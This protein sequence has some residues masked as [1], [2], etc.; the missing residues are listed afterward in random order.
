MQQFREPTSPS[1][2]TIS[3][4]SSSNILSHCLDSDE[5]RPKSSKSELESE[6]TILQTKRD[7]FEEVDDVDDGWEKVEPAVAKKVLSSDSGV[8]TDFS[9]KKR[10][11]NLTDEEETDIVLSDSESDDSLNRGVERAVRR[12]EEEL[13]RCERR[14]K[15]GMNENRSVN[16]SEI[17]EDGEFWGADEV[18]SLNEQSQLHF[19]FFFFNFL[20]AEVE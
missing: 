11:C 18:I 2:L 3:S 9:Q 17:K 16:E 14:I 20:P 10:N 6:P 7:Q 8:L 1:S 4:S 13:I 5:D 15:A 19:F 12:F